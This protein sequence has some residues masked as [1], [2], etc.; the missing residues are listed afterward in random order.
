MFTLHNDERTPLK[1]YD[2]EMLFCFFLKK[3]FFLK[4]THKRRKKKFSRHLVFQRVIVFNQ[5]HTD[6]INA[7]A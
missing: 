2:S 6:V 3:N 4:K 5:T 7:H 1:K